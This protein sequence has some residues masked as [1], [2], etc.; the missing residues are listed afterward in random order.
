MNP[1]AMGVMPQVN[2]KLCPPG[3][4]F[5]TNSRIENLAAH[6]NLCLRT[7]ASYATEFRAAGGWSIV[8]VFAI[9]RSLPP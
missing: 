1:K 2:D 7:H 3:D 4:Y 6:E 8:L 5:R 9:Y